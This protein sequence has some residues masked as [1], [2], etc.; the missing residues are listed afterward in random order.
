MNAP[1][2]LFT[3][4][5]LLGAA[6]VLLRR[7]PTASAAL[8]AVG[9]LATGALTLAAKLDEP[10][11]VLGAS[12]KFGSAW[13]VM[14]RSFVLDQS[15]R[16]A[17]G[18]LYLAVAFVFGGAWM[19]RPE[20]YLFS[21]GI[22]GVGV[23]AASLMVR[24]FLFAAVFLELAAMGGVLM[25]V[26]PSHPSGRGALRM[27]SLYTLAMLAILLAGWMLDTVGVAR[28]APDVALR[29][30][31]LLSIGF[32]VVMAVPPFHHWLPAASERAH[33]YSLAFVAM[34][35]QSAGVFF[36]LKFLDG[37]EWLRTEAA[38]F[39]AMRLAGTVMVVFGAL[40]ALSQRSFSRML[41][42]AVLTGYGVTL[43]AIGTQTAHGYQAAL[44]MIGAHVV[45]LAVCALGL[46]RL[47]GIGPGDDVRV[48]QGAAY[49]APLAAAASLIGVMSLGGF[50]LTAGFP[51]R[52]A[53]LPLLARDH[54]WAAGAVA[55]GI[56]AIAGGAVR[57]LW[58]MLRGE[59]PGPT[60]P[61]PPAETVFLGGGIAL[62]FLLGTFPQIL[63]SLFLAVRGLTNLVP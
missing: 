38:L 4:T 27:L 39:A 18:F 1:L 12:I 32:G 46:V 16:T 24:P 51:P 9:S 8:V 43:I 23:V 35:L 31:L 25:L 41:A 57:W 15:N 33:P 63:S 30:T 47:Q 52:W 6:A 11:L 17:V 29:A 50:P 53:L 49:R 44:G 5:G 36:L 45:G 48:L 58:T 28:G 21:A 37:Y 2:L 59:P 14:G 13:Q 61:A 54:A 22:L 7:R 26:S 55:V 40:A 20:R 34:L 3:A 56:L 62:C 60:P 10:L 42:Y 19:A